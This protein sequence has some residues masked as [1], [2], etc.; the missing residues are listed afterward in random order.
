MLHFKGRVPC[1]RVWPQPIKRKRASNLLYG[2]AS[3]LR[4]ASHEVEGGTEAA[5]GF[6]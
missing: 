1:G 4:T 3:A 5:F 2:E 6:R